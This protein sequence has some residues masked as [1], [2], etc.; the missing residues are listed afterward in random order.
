MGGKG[1]SSGEGQKTQ[2]SRGW[3]LP[4]LFIFLALAYLSFTVSLPLLKPLAWAV[5]LSFTV[6]PVFK[7]MRDR[8]FPRSIT[9]NWAATIATGLI[10]LLLVIP[11]LFTGFVAARE[12]VR[13]YETVADVIAG[14]ESSGEGALTA[15]LPE[16]IVERM[17][18]WMERYPL[19]RTGLQQAAGWAAT[20]AVAASRAVLG[21]T[22]TFVYYLAVIIVVSF[23]LIRDGHL[24]IEYLKD[25]MPLP[26]KE[27]A[28]FFVRA[29]QVL[30]AVVYGVIVTALAQGL[31]GAVGWRIVGLP[32]P[33]FFGA[34]M[35]LFAMIPFLG[36]A[37]VWVPGALYLFYM[38]ETTQALVLLAW[39]VLVVSMVDSLLRPLFISGGGKVHL[40][41][42][43]IGVIGGLA[44][45]GILGLFMGPLVVTL[46][47]FLLESYRTMWKTFFVSR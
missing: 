8:F 46:F 37:L 14:M 38:S 34:L 29:K 4:F 18:P 9:G 26:A 6:Y 42:V 16:Q 44:A 21:S 17:H 1:V 33:V 27:S 36:T 19:L 35:A 22:F 11:S 13:F 40:L 2:M 41:I 47:V 12:G 20:T 23:F 7:R 28:A 3:F 5:L 31:A 25:I 39:G 15:F 45:W 32:S 43:F 10:V 30:Q 24:I